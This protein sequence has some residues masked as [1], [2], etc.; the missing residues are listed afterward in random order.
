MKRL[1]IKEPVNAI[2]HLVT[3]VAAVAGMVALAILARGN[4]ARLL[5]AIVY[6][7][8]MVVLYTASTIYHWWK[9][10]PK[11]EMILRR[12]DHG[13]INFLIAGSATPIFYYGLNGAWR[14]AMLSVIWV[15]AV[16][17]G[18][19]QVVYIRAPR[20]VQTLLYLVL[21]WVAIVPLPQLISNLSTAP[22]IL[23]GAGGLSYTVGAVIY[24][25]K[26]PD[27]LP[28]KFGFHGLFHLLV[29]TGT[30]AHFAAVLLLMLAR[31]V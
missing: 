12:L 16:L 31:G 6:G 21:G 22:L 3:L 17:C 14:T 23:L 20:W 18:V 4:L 28:G 1:P 26:R 30:A 8:S 13:S 25:L 2:S 7:A 19:I 11:R 5:V 9:T 15:L 29:S 10:T 24:A 27:P